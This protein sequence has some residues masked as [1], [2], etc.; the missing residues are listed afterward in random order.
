M[1]KDETPLPGGSSARPGRGR[2]RRVTEDD[3]PLGRLR[4]SRRARRGPRRDL[5]LQHPRDPDRGPDRAVHSGQ[6]GPGRPPLNRWGVRR[7]WAV[8]VILL[9]TTGIVAGFLVSV[10]PSM[11]HQFQ[12]L[13]HDF[14]GYVESLQERSPSFRRISDRYHLTTKI[15]DL[16]ASLPGKVSTGAI[17]SPAACSARCSLR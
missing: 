12:V 7:G 17:R 5:R 13:I 6:P 8:V 1:A 9:I 14:P 11:V 3:V 15:E 16:L 4:R 2:G 10:I